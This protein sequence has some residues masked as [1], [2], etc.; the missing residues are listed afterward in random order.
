[1]AR[2]VPA[3]PEP[4]KKAAGHPLCRPLFGPADP[5]VR[6]ALALLPQALDAVMPLSRNHRADLPEAIRD[7][8]AML[9]YERGGLGRS[10]WSAPR[11][12]SAYLRYFL[13]WNLVRLSR[14]LPGLDLP[15]P[16]CDAEHPVT[17]A[18]LG[19]G[20]LTLPLALWL[21]RPDWRALPLTLICVDT[22]PRPMEMG[23]SLL[24]RMAELCGEELKWTI[25]LV[26]TPLMQ[27]FR[28]VRAPHL[29]MA[30]NVL[31]ELKD[32]PGVSLEDRMA[33]L[34][35][36]VGRTL[37][38]EGAALFV[39]PGTR[40][41]GTLT[42]KLRETALE[43]GLV[44]FAPC[45]HQEPCPLLDSRER[46]W[47]H[48]TL[49]A[50]AP[51][52]LSELARTAHLPKDSLSL[53]FM[54]LRPEGCALPEKAALFP[55]MD[56]RGV[57]GRILSDA[58]PV[59]GMG[60]ARYACTEEGFA[61]I[62]AAEGIPSGALVACRRPSSPRRDAKSGAVELLWQAETKPQR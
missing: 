5:F 48:A 36:A 28:E 22:V 38:P 54:L 12:V 51:A 30:G 14:L 56:P 43:E 42:A 24:E 18:D 27:A 3:M 57:V 2:P 47:C 9:T 37:H 44:P 15:V 45:P 16:P 29:L 61:I 13:P 4:L 34:A 59:P 46:R 62:P 21:S 26:R 19:S 11:Y 33:E 53:S 25:R 1:P 6:K 23:R 58:F 20:P 10:Y 50:E 35:F 55:S 60:R 7:L 39:E 31:N 52:W 8:S 32:K 17:V 40:L 49:L 41:G